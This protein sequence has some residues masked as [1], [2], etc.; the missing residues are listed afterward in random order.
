MLYAIVT[1]AIFAGLLN[2]A[3][4]QESLGLKKLDA[5]FKLFEL[6]DELRRGI[7]DASVPYNR[8]AKY[9]D[10]TLTK[11]IDAL[12]EVNIW[13]AIALVLSYRNDSSIRQAQMNLEN[14]LKK[15]ENE[16]IKQ[17]YD[18]YEICLF[19]F[20]LLRHSAL[21]G[22][23][24]RTGAASIRASVAVDRCVAYVCRKRDQAVR[25]FGSVPE[26]STL[27]KYGGS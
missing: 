12:Q 24:K 13:E 15:K 21:V 14:A 3:L 8:W 7:I 16:K 20:L 1:L 25:L 22:S 5:R 11:T 19:D 27:L 26:T 6:R 23:I 4:R 17:I 18:K 9:M 2:R 10:T